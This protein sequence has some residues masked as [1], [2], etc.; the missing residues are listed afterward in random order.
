M[1]WRAGSYMFCM[2]FSGAWAYSEVRDHP[3]IKAQ[4]AFLFVAFIV[5]ITAVYVVL[6]K[7][8][9]KEK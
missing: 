1:Y 4:V 2:M 8:D 9:F 5:A 6:S 7:N 3:D